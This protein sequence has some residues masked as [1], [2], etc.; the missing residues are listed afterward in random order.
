[1]RPVGVLSFLRKNINRKGSALAYYFAN[2]LDGDENELG[3]S[4]INS[5]HTPTHTVLTVEVRRFTG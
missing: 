5:Y 4:E 2:D 3:V 1:M